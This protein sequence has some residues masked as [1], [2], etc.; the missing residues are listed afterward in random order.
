MRS[1]CRPGCVAAIAAIVIF[2][3][4]GPA[5]HAFAA[6]AAWAGEAAP[7]PAATTDNGQDYV[8]DYPDVWMIQVLILVFV[9]ALIAVAVAVVL[10]LLGLLLLAVAVVLGLVLAFVCLLAAIIAVIATFVFVLVVIACVLSILL[11]PILAVAA[12]IG[13]AKH[14]LSVGIQAAFIMLGAIAGL[15]AGAGGTEVAIWTLCPDGCGAW[16]PILAGGLGLLAG[17]AAAVLLNLAWTHALRWARNRFCM[18]R[19]AA[20]K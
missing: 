5:P 1:V 19:G 17:V 8:D 2:G 18:R 15:A 14:S 3:V 11:L 10:I 7:A 6:T 16:L 13:I 20:P 12:A 9:V 4:I